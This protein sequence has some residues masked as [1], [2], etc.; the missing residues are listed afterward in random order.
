M[1][2]MIG[3]ELLDLT[4]SQ[5]WLNY[6][7]LLPFDQQDIYFTPGYYRIYEDLGDGLANCFVF[8]TKDKI[9]MY[10]YLINS[11]N[12]CGFDLPDKYFDIQGAYGYNGVLTSSLDP[13]F[14]QTF[15]ESF[16]LF[17][18][19]ENI[20]A[21]FMR[22]H[23]VLKNELFSRDYMT[24]IHDRNTVLLDL[25]KSYAEIWD[26]EYS[27]KNRNMIR[28]A[29]RLGYLCQIETTPGKDSIDR[30]ISIYHNSMRLAGAEPY[31]YF[32][33]DYFNNMF[34]Y[35]KDKIYLFNIFNHNGEI[36][37]SSIFLHYND[38]FHYHLSGRNENADNSVNNFLLDSAVKFAKDMGA[39]LFHLGG[40][41]SNANDDSLLKFKKNFSKMIIPFH[42]GKR[43]LNKEV[44]NEVVSQWGNKYPVKAEQYRNILLKYRY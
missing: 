28:K 15:F 2:L 32:N 21:E 3:F 14:I 30:F 22:F 44:Y 43:I 26:T 23:P 13:K 11:V 27:S 16:D 38:Y 33:I 39:K 29:I 37:C 12:E 17:C 4:K 9:A 1:K 35:L 36:I 25:N 10:P 20:I 5:N 31:Y 42:I 34:K 8:K 24:V 19:E 7:Q 6:L 40:G 41:R 18:Q